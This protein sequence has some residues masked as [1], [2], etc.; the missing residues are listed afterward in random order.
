MGPAQVG[1][2]EQRGVGP[3]KGRW[4]NR[5]EGRGAAEGKPGQAETR[6]GGGVIVLSNLRPQPGAAWAAAS[7]T[8]PGGSAPGDELLSLRHRKLPYAFEAGARE[9]RAAGT[10]RPGAYRRLAAQAS[11]GSMGS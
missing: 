9:L 11:P 10:V 2:V 3:G 1:H 6:A 4:G 7:C 8:S 5:R